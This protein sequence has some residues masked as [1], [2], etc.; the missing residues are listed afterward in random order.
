MTM[1]AMPAPPTGQEPRLSE[2]KTGQKIWYGGAADAPGP[3]PMVFIG[4]VTPV[5]DQGRWW[6]GL[7]NE[8][9]GRYTS[10]GGSAF[11]W[12]GESWYGGDFNR[13]W[14]KTEGTVTPAAQ[15]RDRVSDGDQELLYS[16][17]LTSFFNFQTGLRLD[18]D[19]GPVRAWG[20]IGMEGL[21]PYELEASATFYFSDRG[22]AGKLE[23]F[24][25][26]LLTNRLI[27]QPQVE[28]NFYSA[29]DRARGVGQGLSDIDTGLRLRYEIWRKFAPYVG[30]TYDGPL[31]QARRM[32]NASW[33]RERARE[34]R[35]VYRPGRGP[36]FTF[37]IRSW[38]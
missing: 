1:S 3:Q 33:H 26:I 7:L 12:D 19:S 31:G 6:H 2:Q 23:G 21:L 9:E 14:L 24:Y 35:R 29:A 8:F 18:L 15:R 34:G 28:M 20:A 16:R 17:A 36:R 5:N 25:D 4:H 27:L 10:H 30:V 38:F 37:G 32:A 22:V 11:R 13:V